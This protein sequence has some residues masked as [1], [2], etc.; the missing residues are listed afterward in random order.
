MHQTELINQ[1]FLV[2]FTKIF[3]SVFNIKY[4]IKRW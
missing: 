1:I 4:I 2:F 3:C